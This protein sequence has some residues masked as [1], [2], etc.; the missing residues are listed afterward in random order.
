[1]LVEVEAY[2]DG[3]SW[4][5]EVPREDVF[6]HGKA[7]DELLTNIKEAGSLHFDEELK[8][9]KTLNILLISEAEVKRG[10]AR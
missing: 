5:A 8:R 6:N 4:Y 3:T 9:G 2:H 7:L 1:M 10:K